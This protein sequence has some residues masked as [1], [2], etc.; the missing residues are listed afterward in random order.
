MVFQFLFLPNSE[1]VGEPEEERG[2]SE[3]VAAYLGLRCDEAWPREGM[4]VKEAGGEG[5]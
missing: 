1:V 5:A 3:W 4:R 2:K